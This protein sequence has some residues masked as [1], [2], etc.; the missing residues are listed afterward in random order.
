M[1]IRLATREDVPA[2]MTLEARNYVGNLDASQRADGFISILHPQEWFD[3]A[4]DCAGVHVAVTDDG[5]VEGFIAV[6]TLPA[7]AGSASSPIIRAMLELAPSLEYNGRPIAQQRVALRGPVLIDAPAR[8]RGLYTA[9]NTVTREAYRQRFD[10]G[11]VFVAADNHRSLHT[12]TTKLGATSL[13]I[14]EADAKQYH[15]MAFGY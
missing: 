5:S 4:V 1:T 11:V 7:R 2:M 8:G 15:F 14:F 10:I 9:F 13:A 3:G 6:T 12:V